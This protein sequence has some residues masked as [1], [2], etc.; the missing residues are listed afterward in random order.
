MVSVTNSYLLCDVISPCVMVDSCFLV[1]MRRRLLKLA[2]SKI[3]RQIELMHSGISSFA[4][5]MDNSVLPNNQM[6]TTSLY[7]FFV[8]TVF[9]YYYFEG[10][11]LLISCFAFPCIKLFYPTLFITDFSFPSSS[12]YW[13]RQSL[14]TIPTSSNSL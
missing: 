5:Q 1:L 14:L 12:S 3:Y 11:I 4:T 8:W 9:F 10:F 6:I 13:Y 2:L 7:L